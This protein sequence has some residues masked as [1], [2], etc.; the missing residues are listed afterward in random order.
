MT[1]LN[2]F[3]FLNGVTAPCYSKELL[4]NAGGGLV[5]AVSDGF[6]GSIT[7]QGKQN[8]EWYTLGVVDLAKAGT[9]DAITAAGS[10]SVIG[11]AGFSR[12]R[13]NLTAVSGTATVSGR[14]TTEPGTILAASSSESGGGGGSGDSSTATVTITN[15]TS[16]S[17]IGILGALGLDEDGFSASNYRTSVANS[18]P[19]TIKALLYKGKA[20]WNA[21]Y[22]GSVVETCTGDI[23]YDEENPSEFWISGD[24][25]ITFTDK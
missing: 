15:N 25:T 10:Y 22:D 3:T 12:I 17:Q 7:V 19:K 18:A 9:A 8:G 14:L 24:G 6:D 23:E 16:I 13:L 4:N 20:F 21:M 11:V 1:V 5:L 2:E